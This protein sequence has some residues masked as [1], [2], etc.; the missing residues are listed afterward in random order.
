MISSLLP[1]LFNEGQ[2]L[3]AS[4][5]DLFHCLKFTDVCTAVN[6]FAVK[7]KQCAV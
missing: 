7:Y 3:S 2:K 6:N 1:H 5:K 4:S